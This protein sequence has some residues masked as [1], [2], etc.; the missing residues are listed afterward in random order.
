MTAVLAL[1]AVAIASASG[2]P[3]LVLHRRPALGQGLSAGALC[4][5]AVLG[6]AAAVPVLAGAPAAVLHLAWSQP[7]ASL[8]VRID[9]LSAIFLLPILVVPALGSIYG[10][11]Y[12]PQATQGRSA[13]RLQLWY[14]LVT[15]SMAL[16]VLADNAMLFLF[17]WEVMALGGFFLVRAEP[18]RKD[19]QAASWV[20][21]AAAH[22]G[23]FAIFAFF[24]AAGKRPRQLRLRG[25]GR[26]PLESAPRP[27]GSRCSRWSG[28]G[29]RPG[30][31]PST[32]GSPGPTR[33]P[34]ATSRR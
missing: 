29:S 7:H 12:W 14:G 34:P 33:P 4:L 25:L 11:G 6:I 17:A 32:S 16:V 5:A 13:V 20:Y 3:G 1:L 8:A 21:L 28:S 18:D 31:S 23:T 9:A 24:A 10:L 26:A 22:V 30:S 19:A 27:G 2:L 15:G